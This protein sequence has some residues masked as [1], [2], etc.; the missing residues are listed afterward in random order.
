MKL[1]PERMRSSWKKNIVMMRFTTPLM[2]IL[3]YC[4][5]HHHLIDK[6]WI[7]STIDGATS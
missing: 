6:I 5:C 3:V 4:H 7:V 2:R 1:D